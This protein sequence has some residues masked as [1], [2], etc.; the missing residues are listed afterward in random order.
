VKLATK[1]LFLILSFVALLQIVSSIC[2][3]FTSSGLLET[4]IEDEITAI[5]QAQ[6][7]QSQN[8]FEAIEQS[9]SAS[10]ERGEMVKF[11]KLLENQTSILGL[12]EFSLYGTDHLVQYSTH[13]K[14]IGKSLASDV[15]S[16]MKD[17]FKRLLI[18][19]DDCFEIY[20]PQKITSD[21][22]RCHLDWEE[23]NVGGVT[24]LR[25]SKEIVNKAQAKAIET[26]HQ[27]GSSILKVT[28]L[29]SVSFLLLLTFVV[30][31]TM[32]R[33]VTQPLD[34]ALK[35]AH[36]LENNDYNT[37]IKVRSK[38]EIGEMGEALNHMADVLQV[39]R[40]DLHA[41]MDSL[42][43]VMSMVSNTS[44]ELHGYS[45][46]LL[47]TA[48]GL[49]DSSTE[50]AAS[51]E[52]ISASM[53]EIGS[54]TEVNAE[55]AKEATSQINIART[56]ATDGS[57][58]MGDLVGAMTEIGEANQSISHI[59][60]MIEDIAFQTNLLS[61]NAAVEAARAGVH[62]K[63]F[64]V[65]ADEVRSLAVRSAEAAG[66]TTSLIQNSQ[67]KARRG[68]VL[69][70]ETAESLAS[71]SERMDSIVTMMSSIASA[72]VEQNAGIKQ[73][74]EGLM[75][76]E[77]TTQANSLNAGK[78]AEIAK[79]IAMQSKKLQELLEQ[80]EHGSELSH[81]QNELYLGYEDQW[82]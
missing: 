23:G 50:Q 9:V 40:K 63:G 36:A 10:L 42:Q 30:F 62:G 1:T 74:S 20:Q 2:Q 52:E 64:A 43:N 41:N 46:D 73:T 65:V 77:Q 6:I 24:S 37:R 5:K 8:I 80:S 82:G 81:A 18:E 35:L 67:D 54:Q 12:M 75:R 13:N 68:E 14:Y 69:V 25:F 21:C 47:H 58:K 7:T 76:I 17:N 57:Q 79:E 56:A 19:R 32:K 26:S 11:K 4:V 53:V 66:K 33:Q 3:Y 72:S 71:I 49:N 78:T 55:K 22:V 34:E 70:N 45:S 38:D 27:L 39:Q 29:C 61:L 44:Q 28:V 48:D 60:K 59:I 51:I 15:R 16:Q 31:M